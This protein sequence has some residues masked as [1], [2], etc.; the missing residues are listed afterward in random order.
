M[1]LSSLAV[2]S[3]GRLGD[4]AKS[5]NILNPPLRSEAEISR[6]TQPRHTHQPAEW[7]RMT[8]PRFNWAAIRQLW[9]SAI[10]SIAASTT[11]AVPLLLALLTLSACQPTAFAE[12]PAK[13]GD[14]T[15]RSE[16]LLDIIS[17]ANAGDSAAQVTLGVMFSAGRGLPQDYAQAVIWFRKA[18][19]QGH[20]SAQNNLGVIYANG[21]GVPEDDAQAVAWYRKS[22]QQGEARAQFNLGRMYDNGEGVAEDDAVAAA[23]YRKAAEQGDAWAQVNLGFMYAN[24]E[25]VAENDSLAVAWYR[26]AAEQG[27]AGAQFNLGGM[28]DD[29]EGVAEDDAVAAAWYRKA[30]EKGHAKAQGNLGAMYANGE[31]VPQDYVQAYAWFNLSAAQGHPMSR[32]YRDDVRQSMTPDQIAQGQALSREWQQAMAGPGN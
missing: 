24:G 6:R 25:G 26:K 16:E 28:Y 5:D 21:Y 32:V 9:E 2:L 11:V 30:A 15:H 1:H 19:E 14:A 4:R 13:G 20:A 12:P 18:A 23:W 29:G 10:C 8:L 31:G 3:G 17:R 22:A 27:L 7:C